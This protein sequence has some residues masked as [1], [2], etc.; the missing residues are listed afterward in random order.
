[1]VNFCVWCYRDSRFKCRPGSGSDDSC[2]LF[3]AVCQ[4]N[5]E[6]YV[7]YA[8]S[9]SFFTSSVVV[10][11]GRDS[12]VGIVTR[13]GLDGPGIESRWGAR[14]SSSVQIIPGAHVASCRMGAGFLFAGPKGRGASLTTNSHLVRRLKK[15]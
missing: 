2:I 9:D 8:E 11:P 5:G 14:F 4:A 7:T 10:K 3:C 6:W 12:S 13:Y 1:M 15:E